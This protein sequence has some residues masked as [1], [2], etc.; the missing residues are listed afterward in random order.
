MNRFL[1]TLFATAALVAASLPA[2]AETMRLEW[3]MQG[4]FAGPIVAFEKGYY[5]EAGVD[6]QL[7]P[8]GPDIKASVTVATG[9]DTYGIGHANQVISA[10]ANGAPL[11]MISQH[12]QKSATT[13]IARKDSGITS[14]KDMAG[15]SVGL[16]FGGDEQEF[17]AMLA[18][19]GIDQSAV[20]IISQG[21]DIIGWLNKDYEV[22]QVT[23][24][25]ELLQVYR[26][27]FKKEDL[28]FIDPP[29][30]ASLVSGGLFTTEKQIQENPKA[31]QAVV[32]ATLRGWKEALADPK[33]AAEIVLKYNSELKLD[34]QVEQIKAMGDLFCA[35]PTLKG[36]FG[37]SELKIYEVAQKILVGAKLIDQPIDLNKAFTNAFWEKAPADY[38]TLDCK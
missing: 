9:A 8:A 33:A 28:V 32:D 3:V 29:D 2:M 18:N 14:I 37:K 10:R 36:E 16:W 7:Q 15:H 38:K 34:E 1:K 22:M 26:Q 27:G 23:L 25:N 13:Y 31:V 17:L 35:G 6:L 11:V 30:D 21:Y 12:G 5:K 19:A 24:Y 4:Q 20:K